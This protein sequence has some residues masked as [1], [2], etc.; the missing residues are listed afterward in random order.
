M[1]IIGIDLSDYFLS[2][3]I[4][5]VFIKLL[6]M[7]VFGLVRVDSYLNYVIEVLRVGVMDVFVFFYM[8]CLIF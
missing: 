1:V 6:V 5:V 8:I 2:D 4:Y 7:G 3:V